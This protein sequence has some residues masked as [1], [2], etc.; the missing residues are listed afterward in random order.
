MSISSF[1]KFTKIMNIEAWKRLNNVSQKSLLTHL[2]D[3]CCSFPY[4]SFYIHKHFQETKKN[5][6]YMERVEK[7]CYTIGNA[8]IWSTT[9]LFSSR[10]INLLCHL[11]WNNSKKSKRIDDSNRRKWWLIPSLN[12]IKLGGII[13]LLLLCNF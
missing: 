12:Y 13:W 9:G 8:E 4:F 3:N 7:Y 5:I 6:N 10:T 11:V 2:L 1:F